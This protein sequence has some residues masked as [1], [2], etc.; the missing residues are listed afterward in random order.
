MNPATQAVLDSNSLGPQDSIGFRRSLAIRPAS[1][2]SKMPVSVR[3]RGGPVNDRSTRPLHRWGVVP[4]TL[5]W[6]RQRIELHTLPTMSTRCAGPIIHARGAGGN[7]I[8]IYIY[9]PLRFP[10]PLVD[11]LLSNKWMNTSD[12]LAWV[13]NYYDIDTL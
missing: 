5:V 4:L 6:F 11:I 12:C 10:D 7:R 13:S 2:I 8:I 3:R 1:S 9:A